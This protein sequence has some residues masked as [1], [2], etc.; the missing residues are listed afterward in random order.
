ML[1]VGIGEIFTRNK[2]KWKVINIKEGNYTCETI[3]NNEKIIKNYTKLE[4]YKI[5]GDV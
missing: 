3:D 1:L 4:M 5:F 2:R